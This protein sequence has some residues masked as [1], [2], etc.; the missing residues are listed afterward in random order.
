MIFPIL[1]VKFFLIYDIFLSES[2]HFATTCNVIYLF[3]ILDVVTFLDG[4]LP[5]SV[6]VECACDRRQ[7]F[8]LGGKLDSLECGD[9]ESV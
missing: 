1:S 6:C 5:L 3:E 2:V 9:R 4:A 7:G 8:D